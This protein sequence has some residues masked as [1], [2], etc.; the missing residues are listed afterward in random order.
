MIAKGTFQIPVR[1]DQSTQGARRVYYRRWHQQWPHDDVYLRKLARE[2]PPSQPGF[3]RCEF[4][5]KLMRQS[6]AGFNHPGR[7]DR[8]MIRASGFG[9]MLPG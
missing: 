7:S 1:A 4:L 5:L 9:G 6:H 3:S 2:V 8:V